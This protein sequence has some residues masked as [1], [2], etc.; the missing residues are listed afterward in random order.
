VTDVLLPNDT[1]SRLHR[2]DDNDDYTSADDRIAS[3][4]RK[5]KDGRYESAAEE[6]RPGQWK[7]TVRVWKDRERTDPDAI[8]TA[9]RSTD[10]PSEIAAAFPLE[11]AETAALS[12]ALRFLG[13]GLT[14][15]KKT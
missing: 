8:A 1:S 3:F 14:K 9:Y 10:D 5:Y 7:V 15:R 2:A 4:H 12:R 13:I 11:T 6:I